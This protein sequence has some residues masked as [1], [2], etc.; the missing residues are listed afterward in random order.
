MFNCPRLYAISPFFSTPSFPLISPR[1]HPVYLLNILPALSCPCRLSILC[2]T[3]VKK[4]RSRSYNRSFPSSNPSPHHKASATTR[5]H[6]P[7][8]RCPP[9]K[10][11]K[12]LSLLFP[13]QAVFSL[14]SFV[15][16]PV[17]EPAGLQSTR[18]MVF[19]INCC[20]IS[21]RMIVFR[22]I[23]FRF[24]SRTSLQ[25]LCVM[26]YRR[27][28]KQEPPTAIQVNYANHTLYTQTSLA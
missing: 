14:S 11:T 23:P 9:M 28:N 25:G 3:H 22:T 10:Q 21:L 5:K 15:L 7:I 1:S 2:T 18:F 13:L 17:D 8:M 19:C 4:G 16:P 24:Y 6:P 26:I 12:T 20:P 27:R